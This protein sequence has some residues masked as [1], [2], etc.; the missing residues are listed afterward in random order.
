MLGKQVA[1]KTTTNTFSSGILAEIRAKFQ[2][3]FSFLGEIFLSQEV[4]LNA[5]VLNAPPILTA[6]S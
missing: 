4:V 3:V 5:P 1:R 6:Q 2:P